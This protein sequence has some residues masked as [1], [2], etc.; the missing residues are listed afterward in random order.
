VQPNSLPTGDKSSNKSSVPP[1]KPV[2]KFVSFNKICA[3]IRAVMD[4]PTADSI[5]AKIKEELN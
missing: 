2:D 3:I 5:I 4:A 1:N